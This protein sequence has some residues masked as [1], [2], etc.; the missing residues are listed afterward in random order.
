MDAADK[1]RDDHFAGFYGVVKSSLKQPDADKQK[2]AERVFNVLREYRKSILEKGYVEGLSA[3]YNLLGFTD[4][5]TAIDETE[6]HF[7]TLLAER[8]QENIDKPKEDIRKIRREIDTLYT[9]M[10]NILDAQ[11]LADGLGGDIVAY[12]YA[13][14]RGRIPERGTKCRKPGVAFLLQVWRHRKT[15]KKKINI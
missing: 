1:K 2:A 9:A 6:Q 11:L 8:T 13:E 4:W 15:I 7:Q 14:F 5:V 3:I 10:A 12:Q